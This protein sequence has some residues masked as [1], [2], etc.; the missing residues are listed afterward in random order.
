MRFQQLAVGER[1]E[2][3]GEI[4][5]KVDALIAQVE[6]SHTRRLIPRYAQLNAPGHE[7]S[8]PKGQ[9]VTDPQREAA[10]TAF[11]AFYARCLQIIE[12]LAVDLPAER[13]QSVRG[14]FEAARQAYLHQSC[15]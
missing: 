10:T 7:V 4:Y 5:V 11:D 6:G 15:R 3:E 2:F 13:V 14:S 12:E 8:E 1:F 9:T